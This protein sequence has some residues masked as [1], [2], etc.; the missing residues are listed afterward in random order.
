MRVLLP[1][2]PEPPDVVMQGAVIGD[3]PVGI[4]FDPW[5][6]LGENWAGEVVL[7]G[8]CPLSAMLGNA[9]PRAMIGWNPYFAQ[10]SSIGPMAI[11]GGQV[12]MV[13]IGPTISVN[14]IINTTQNFLNSALPLDASGAWYPTPNESVLTVNQEYPW[15]MVL[16][17]DGPLAAP[18]ALTN[19]RAEIVNSGSLKTV[20]AA[21]LPS[22]F[23]QKIYETWQ[24]YQVFTLTGTTTDGSGAP[25]GNC[26]VI[27]YQTGWQ[28]VADAPVIIAET[29]SDGSGAFSLSL[30]N[31][32]YQLVAYKA[33]G[34]DVAGITKNNV[35]PVA[36]V[37]VYLRDPTVADSAGPGFYPAVGDVDVGT[38][39]GPTGVEYTGTLVQPGI[40]DVR[41]GTTYGAGGTE[42]TGTLVGTSGAATARRGILI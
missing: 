23:G 19:P 38:N 9:V 30:R 40:G 24:S 17:S 31:I 2:F 29:V 42:F 4:P 28:Y 39:Y 15:S 41:S 11:Q 10:P 34:T 20:R 18:S 32:D 16:R 12:G 14:P 5:P 7:Q 1:T 26:R 33:G 35:T 36:A 37:T 25:L 21:N 27:A 8:A 22:N 6:N 3:M 13:P